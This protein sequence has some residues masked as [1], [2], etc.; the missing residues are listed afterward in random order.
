M[1][2]TRLFN[3]SSSAGMCKIACVRFACEGWVSGS[4][5]SAAFEYT[6]NPSASPSAVKFHPPS[7]SPPNDVRRILAED[8]IDERSFSESSSNALRKHAAGHHPETAS[9]GS[10]VRDLRGEVPRQVKGVGAA[11]L[12]ARVGLLEHAAVLAGCTDSLRVLA[13]VAE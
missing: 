3:G 1:H 2:C 11:G 6:P 10:A 8:A 12:G 7:S 4:S 9:A 13:T 5:R